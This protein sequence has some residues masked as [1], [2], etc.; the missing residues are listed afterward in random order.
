MVG[1]AR[2][3]Q[4]GRTWNEDGPLHHDAVQ[5]SALHDALLHSVVRICSESSLCPTR[6]LLHRPPNL[7]APYPHV[8]LHRGHVD[9]TH[10]HGARSHHSG[11]VRR[12]GDRSSLDRFRGTNFLLDPAGLRARLVHQYTKIFRRRLH[13]YA[14]SV[15]RTGSNI[16]HH[17]GNPMNPKIL[18]QMMF[19][20]LGAATS[21]PGPQMITFERD[22]AVWIT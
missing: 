9:R 17:P 6:Y 10:D 1:R 18:S 16:L 11:H 15:P 14:G 3:G 13:L 19:V 5:Q 4:D 22:D 12:L 8:L 7:R 2:E 20:S 21:S